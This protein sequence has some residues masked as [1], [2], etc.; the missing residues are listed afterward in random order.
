MPQMRPILLANPKS[1]RGRATRLRDRF[2]IALTVAGMD[3]LALDIPSNGSGGGEAWDPARFSGGS[4]LVVFGGDGTVNAVA[5]QAISTATP[6]Y[7]VPTGNENLFAR[8][9]AMNRSPDRLMTALETRR[10]QR[11]DTA[12]CNGRRFLIM[13]SLGPDAQVIRRVTEA[14]T[15][16]IGHLTYVW[17]V[18]RQLADPIVPRVTVEIDGETVVRDQRGLV[19][20][21]NSR[22]YAMRVDPATRARF[23][24][25]KLDVVFIPAR[26][27]AS[28]VPWFVRARTRTHLGARGLVY[29][30]GRTIRV[31][32]T[33]S[34]VQIDGEWPGEHGGEVRC[35]I[36]PANLPVLRPV[37]LGD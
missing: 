6:I 24:S 19:I 18:A 8:A 29:G 11:V 33:E 4:A 23:D 26:L 25:G 31:V 2:Q 9:F 21:A 34:P 13:A 7:H 16:A 35:E 32:A 36:E 15:K 1:G 17:P 12:R 20:I 28:L 10:V 27:S 30:S 5:D 37:L 22:E 3:P 14:R